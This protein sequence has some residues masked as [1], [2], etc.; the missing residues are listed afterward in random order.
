[1]PTKKET[2]TQVPEEFTMSHS[3]LYMSLRHL[4]GLFGYGEQSPVTEFTRSLP[5]WVLKGLAGYIRENQPEDIGRL[6]S[7]YPADFCRMWMA[8][9]DLELRAQFLNERQRAGEYLRDTSIF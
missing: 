7:M 4:A 5:C 8:Q 2:P 1:M 3:A 6:L 9:E